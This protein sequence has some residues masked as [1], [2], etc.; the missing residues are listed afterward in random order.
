MIAP[1]FANPITSVIVTE[2]AVIDGWAWMWV[3]PLPD[4]QQS[5]PASPHLIREF[6]ISAFR[7]RSAGLDVLMPPEFKIPKH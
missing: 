6:A 5:G 4:H 2:A 1:V 7:A 3:Y